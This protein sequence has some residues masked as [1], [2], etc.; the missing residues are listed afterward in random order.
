GRP[1]VIAGDG[2]QS[3]QFV[4]VDDLARGIV[5]SIGESARPGVYNLV[6]D[7]SITV[8]AIAD[9]VR[10]L[11]GDVPIV[12]ARPRVADVTTPRVSA[13]RAALEL[14]WRVRIPFEAGVR[15]Y[16]DWVIDTSSSPSSATDSRIAGSASAVLNHDPT[17]L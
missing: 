11:V 7:E 12:H 13:Q 4:Y 16:G 10:G 1:L 3:R 6:G 5:A 8:R 17:E 15:S 9:H 14:G 2:L